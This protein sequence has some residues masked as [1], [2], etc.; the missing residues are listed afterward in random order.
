MSNFLYLYPPPH[1]LVNHMITPLWVSRTV[2]TGGAMANKPFSELTTTL[3]DAIA[4]PPP[5][6][7]NLYF[8]ETEFYNSPR[9]TSGKAKGPTKRR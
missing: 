4:P 3:P 6:C 9:C 7:C 8:S 5:A 1:A 2:K